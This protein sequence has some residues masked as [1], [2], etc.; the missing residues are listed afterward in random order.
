MTA[1]FHI[2]GAEHERVEVCIRSYEYAPTGEYHD[3]NWLAVKVSLSVGA[4]RGSFQASFLTEEIVLFRE[5]VAALYETLTGIARFIAMENQ[6][7]L[8]LSGNGRG[9][10]AIKGEARDQCGVGNRLEFEL[11]IDQTQLA[12]TMK[13]LDAVIERFPVRA[14]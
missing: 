5:G 12:E 4:F 8:E 2:G 1:S 9:N 14:G 11:N 13:E 7:F 10:I 6:L 3:D